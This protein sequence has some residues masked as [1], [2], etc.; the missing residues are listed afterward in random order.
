MFI[1]IY[2]IKELLP[3]QQN[4][5]LVN[6]KEKIQVFYQDQ[7]YRSALKEEVKTPIPEEYGGTGGYSPLVSY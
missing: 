6:T 4:V 3:S 5:L 1:I 7:D 2:V